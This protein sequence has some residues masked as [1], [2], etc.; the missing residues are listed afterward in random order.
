M[1]GLETKKGLAISTVLL[2]NMGRVLLMRAVLI[3]CQLLLVVLSLWY[4]GIHLSLMPIMV[5][6]SLYIMV[7]VVSLFILMGRK[8]LLEWVYFLQLLLDVLFLTL[9]LY[10]S[11]G[12][13]NPFISLYLLPLIVVST[14][15]ERRYAWTMS[16]LVLFC[17][18]LMVFEYHPLFV[19]EGEHANQFAG[20]HLHLLG[21]WFSFALSVGLIVFF[22]MRMS[23][24][25]RQRDMR[26]A[27]MRETAERDSHVLA[28]GAMAAGAAHELGTPLATMAVV[29]HE[30]ACDFP[31]NQEIRDQTSLL[32]H[33]LLRCKQVLSQL[34]ASAGQLFA[35]GGQRM[36]L[37]RYVR[38]TVTRWQVMRPQATLRLNLQTEGN[39][40][41][42]LLDMTL[43]QALYNI[44]NNAVDAEPHDM[45]ISFGW[46][47]QKVWIEVQDQGQG[48]P[49]HVLEQIDQP[50]ISSKNSGHGLGLFLSRAVVKRLGGQLELYNPD[51]G[52]ACARI[53]LPKEMA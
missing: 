7:N 31:N 25:I 15:L 23:L 17:Y 9:F 52:G 48:F 16:A 44:L 14:T 28:L 18:T 43:T 50:D 51:T 41:E 33:E 22:I 40:P 6:I 5:I 26:L 20:F 39:A 10:Y 36:A 34:S 21:M 38:D 12:Y 19:M 2:G 11:G 35:E 46:N 49:Q 53:V 1:H 27:K 42:F 37:D 13:T 47:E 4:D 29:S 30:L 3:L 32:K 8:G 45:V 24:S